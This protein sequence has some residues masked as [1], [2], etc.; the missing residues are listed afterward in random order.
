MFIKNVMTSLRA[1]AGF[2]LGQSNFK[3]PQYKSLRNF[4]LTSEQVN[5]G[6]F[7]LNNVWLLTLTSF[8]A[9]KHTIQLKIANLLQGCIETKVS[10]LEFLTITIIVHTSALL[11]G[12]VKPDNALQYWCIS[13]NIHLWNT[14]HPEVKLISMIAPTGVPIVLAGAYLSSVPS[15]KC[16]R[17]SCVAWSIR[18][19]LIYDKQSSISRP[20]HQDSL[21]HFTPC[22]VKQPIFPWPVPNLLESCLSTNNIFIENKSSFTYLER[23]SFTTSLFLLKI[24]GHI[25]DI[26]FLKEIRPLSLLFNRFRKWIYQEMLLIHLPHTHLRHVLSGGTSFQKRKGKRRK[27]QINWCKLFI[28]LKQV[29]GENKLYIITYVRSVI[30]SSTTSL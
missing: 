20:S 21:V 12:L 1:A 23:E 11:L 27:K 25:N 2:K 9:N 10:F 26:N 14:F 5:V 19:A 30:T 13:F 17:L 29:L 15:E 8:K 7:C 22:N 16:C 4:E 18:N 24:F 6:L 3:L 28:C